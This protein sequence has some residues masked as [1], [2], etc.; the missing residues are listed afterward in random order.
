M[1]LQEALAGMP[2][3]YTHVCYLTND[4]DKSMATLAAMGVKDMKKVEF[5]LGAYVMA[6]LP[7]G[8]ASPGATEVGTLRIEII[9]PKSDSNF[10]RE[11]LDRF[12]QGLHH[13][14]VLVPD[15]D[16]YLEA[17]MSA[18]CEV[19]LDMRPKIVQ[20]DD[21]PASEGAAAAGNFKMCYLDCGAIGF[22]TIE[23]AG[24]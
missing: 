6:D 17:F 21:A 7:D 9:E 15:F 2:L 11:H 16:S 1:Q 22:P 4:L 12:G 13:V 5:A 20:T 19:L 14:G 18:G 3:T 8:F 10:Y 24:T 23:L